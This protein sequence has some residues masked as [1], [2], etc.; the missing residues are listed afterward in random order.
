[1]LP[2]L[3]LSN[4]STEARDRLSSLRGRAVASVAHVVAKVAWPRDPAMRV[5]FVACAV[6]CVR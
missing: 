2:L 4:I 3:I 5:L 6:Y 1:M